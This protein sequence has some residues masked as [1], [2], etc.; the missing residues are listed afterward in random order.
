LHVHRACI[1]FNFYRIGVPVYYFHFLIGFFEIEMLILLFKSVFV[2]ACRHLF[3]QLECSSVSLKHASWVILALIMTVISSRAAKKVGEPAEEFQVEKWESNEPIHL[4]DYKGQ[5]V[6]LLFFNPFQES[7]AKEPAKVM[8]QQV[9]E[10]FK[11]QGGNQHGVP[12][13]FLTLNTF[14]SGGTAQTNRIISYAGLELVGID[15]AT[16]DSAAVNQFEYEFLPMVALLNGVEDS[17]SHSLWEIVEIDD[18]FKSSKVAAFKNKVNSIKAPANAAPTINSFSVAP[19]FAGETGVLKWSVT[20]A[21]E[22]QIDHGVGQV[23]GVSSN[24]QPSEETTYTLTASNASGDAT[25]TATLRIFPP[26]ADSDFKT[27]GTILG[28]ELFPFKDKWKFMH[29]VDGVDPVESDLDFYQTWMLPEGSDYDGKEFLSEGQGILGYGLITPKPGTGIQGVITYVGLPEEGK[30]RTAYFRKTFTLARAHAQVGFE[31]LAVDGAVVYLDG[32][33]VVRKNFDQPDA[34][35]NLTASE[36]DYPSSVAYYGKS[37]LGKGE[38]TLAVAVHQDA[39]TSSNLGFD[40]RLISKDSDLMAIASFVAEQA[41]I[42]SGGSTNLLWDVAGTGLT[43]S[44]NQGIG[45]VAGEKVLV[46][47]TQDTNYTLTA[48][49]GGL[50]KTK[51]VTVKVEPF[52]LGEMNPGTKG[53]GITFEDASSGETSNTRNV[54]H[55]DLGW[56]SVGVADITSVSSSQ[57]DPDSAANKKQFHL[58][59]GSVEI[60]SE[61]IS[62][63][64]YNNVSVSLDVHAHDT[65]NGFEISDKIE[66]FALHSED[67]LAFTQ[68][69][70]I[71]LRGSRDGSRET[72]LDFGQLWSKAATG[73][74]IVTGEDGKLTSVSSLPKQVPDAAQVIRIVIRAQNDSEHEHFYLDNLKVTGTGAGSA[75]VWVDWWI[76]R[77]EENL[78]EA[79]KV[80]T[81]DPDGDGIS[82]LAEYLFGGHPTLP[83]PSAS[84]PALSLANNAYTFTFYRIKPG[85][86]STNTYTAEYRADLAIGDWQTEGLTLK[87]S[88]EGV[89]QTGLPDGKDFSQSIYERAEATLPA[90][91]ME[92][93]G[94]LFMRI[95]VERDE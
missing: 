67:G 21:E 54:G 56:T 32:K 5:A 41:T 57:T 50:T 92:G 89:D 90:D 86:D 7:F 6:I 27:S 85:L 72:A 14:P 65:N 29:P 48:Q 63:N 26:V 46:A 88:T 74:D 28:T 78:D 17:P 76:A 49:G 13:T 69:Q 47:P 1:I 18:D 39:T 35:A 42:V 31:I 82:N 34:Y 64:N 83:D 9:F 51:S 94:H 52:S 84:A 71:T 81:A 38:H 66:V 40:L 60:I 37:V 36:V 4:S 80:T 45:E 23:Q 12:V 24:V 58:N 53:I 22:L 55:T 75:Q 91:Q 73:L 70:L 8:Q 10:H 33:E 87:T 79:L 93:S 95:R 44:L 59:N 19:I 68:T 2:S 25:A 77:G 16:K 20:G 3:R 11:A 30:R 15:D 43:L 62:T 61:R